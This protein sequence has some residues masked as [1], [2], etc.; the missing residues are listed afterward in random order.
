[1]A[2]YMCLNLARCFCME[3]SASAPALPPPCRSSLRRPSSAQASSI[4]PCARSS[5]KASASSVVARRREFSRAAVRCNT[6]STSRWAP[7][8]AAEGC[9]ASFSSQVVSAAARERTCRVRPA[10]SLRKPSDA[11]AT[12]ACWRPLQSIRTRSDPAF[13]RSPAA[14]ATRSARAVFSLCS[15]RCSVSWRPTSSRHLSAEDRSSECRAA[16][17][18]WRSRESASSLASSWASS[19]NACRSLI[20]SG[21]AAPSATGRRSCSEM[22]A[23]AATAS[24]WPEAAASKAQRSR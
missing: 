16:S 1:M 21:E 7:A 11:A 17:S 14:A 12:S 22:A 15:R 6:R 20:S 9:A 4:S 3:T 5:S 10:S 23:P 2:T 13:W 18:A 19:P 24:T 8:S